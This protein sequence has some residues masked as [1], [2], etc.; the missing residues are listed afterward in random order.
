MANTETDMEYPWLSMFT[1]NRD[2]WYG[3]VEDI[4]TAMDIV[5]E[6][7]YHTHT[8]YVATRATKNFGH[9]CALSGW[10]LC[11]WLWRKCVISNND[12]YTV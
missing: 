10:I 4:D 1:W 11:F 8:S 3:R 6:C 9:I 12:Y 2:A 7:A 5:E